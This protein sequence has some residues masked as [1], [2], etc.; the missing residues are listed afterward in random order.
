MTITA[1]FLSAADEKLGELRIGPV[2]NDDR[3]N[4]TN[5]LRR[6]G[7]AAVPA[8]TRRIRVTATST[9]TDTV[10]SAIAD[11]VKLTLDERPRDPVVDPTPAPASFGRATNVTI[12][13]AARRIGAKGPIR[14]RV[15]NRNA[16]AVNGTLSGRTAN[17]IGAGRKR[18]PAKL[19]TKRFTVAATNRKTVKLALPKKLRRELG[20]KGK[21]AVRLSVVVADPAGNRRTVRKSVML[22]LK[23]PRAGKR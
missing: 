15:S 13:L 16:F 18:K 17:A 9:D 2:T 12:G 6:A 22:R 19:M 7:S 3:R 11:N 8:G 23:K 21:L 5:L 1:E 10:S 4:V 20:R 14:V